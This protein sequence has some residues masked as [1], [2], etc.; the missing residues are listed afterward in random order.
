MVGA[1]T[2]GWGGLEREHNPPSDMKNRA[3]KQ[4]E[5][6]AED[7]VQQIIALSFEEFTRDAV[8]R[9]AWGIMMEEVEALCGPRYRP[10]RGSAH[11]R[12]GTEKGVLRHGA[13]RE[14]I[15]RPRVRH[16]A[17]KGEVALESY[18]YIS[19]VENHAPLITRMMSEGMSARGMSRASDAALGKSRIAEAWV[20]KGREHVMQLRQADLRAQEWAAL[21][22][23]GVWLDKE[24]CAIV[25]LGIDAQGDKQVLDF[26]VGTSESAECATRLLRRLVERGF[27]PK[28]KHRLLS[29]IDGAA[30]L[31]KALHE[32][33]PNI[34]VQEC[35]V[36]V[37]RHTLD[38]LRRSDR[39]EAS[40]L[41]QRLRLAQGAQAAEEAFV[42]LHAWIGQRHDGAHASLLAAKERLLA[43]HQL[44]LG[45]S[46][47]RS[48][49]STNA[50]E[51]TLRNWRQSTHGVNRWR[52]EGDMATRWLASGLLWAQQGFHRVR[53]HEQMNRLMKALSEE[54]EGTFGA[55]ETG[56]CVPAPL[57]ATPPRST[58][59][60]EPIS[61]RKRLASARNQTKITP[62]SA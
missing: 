48:L 46:L 43:V 17:G 22:L 29:I 36:H 37:E 58:C 12:A 14:A 25:A 6:Q 30:A 10:T 54:G 7:E 56:S 44:N 18:G 27:G 33:W 15:R 5:E 42:E 59:T 55:R 50:I 35:L 13:R 1:P 3:S 41:F 21:M 28:A 45:E 31:R 8:R 34:L 60:T 4:T 61:R 47:Q 38:R 11:R 39:D 16:A 53:G 26:E 20:A 32:Q 51:N 2:T 40:G 9:A 49:L 23:D 19:S 52:R 62:P 24:L 57:G